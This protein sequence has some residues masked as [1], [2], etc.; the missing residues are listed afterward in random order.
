MDE[1]SLDPKIL[2]SRLREERNRL[3][4]TQSELA[5]SGGVRRVTVYLYEKGDRT[6][7]LE[8]LDRLR[9]CGVSF[10]YVLWGQ[11]RPAKSSGRRIDAELASELYRLVDRYAVDSRGR[12]LHVDSRAELFDT[13]VSMAINLETGQVDR[14]AIQNVLEK[15]A[16]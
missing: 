10:E 14:S 12:S 8:F 6:P 4:L 15:F 1:K 11:R 5:E 16:A 13:L 2:G 7:T 9:H 3:G